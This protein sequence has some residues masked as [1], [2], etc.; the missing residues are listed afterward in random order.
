MYENKATL[1]FL[2]RK[3]NENH[4]EIVEDPCSISQKKICAFA[5]CFKNLNKRRTRKEH[6]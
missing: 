4:V 2:K 6:L 1:F 3:Q 5:F